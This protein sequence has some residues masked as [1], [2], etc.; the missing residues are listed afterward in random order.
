MGCNGVVNADSGIAPKPIESDLA[1][2]VHQIGKDLLHG[3]DQGGRFIG[4]DPVKGRL[5]DSAGLLPDKCRF[6]TAKIGHFH[7]SD[8][9]ILRVGIGSHQ[10][11]RLHPRNC[12]GHCGKLDDRVIRQSRNTGPFVFGQDDEDAPP[13]HIH[14]DPLQRPIEIHRVLSADPHNPIERPFFHSEVWVSW[15]DAFHV[16]R[17]DGVTLSLSL[18]LL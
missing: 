4:R 18:S 8:A 11:L 7:Q 16:G 2:Q 15:I 3:H 12:L 6:F 10:P 1:R 13:G 17:H 5:E 14:P 9:P